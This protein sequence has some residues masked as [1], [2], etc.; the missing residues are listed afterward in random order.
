VDAPYD[1]SAITAGIAHIGVGGFHRAHQAMYV[2]RLLRD[3]RAPDWG[4]LGVGVL[5]SDRAMRDALAA[6]D[7]LYTLVEKHAD[8]TYEP[9]VIGSLVDYVLAPEDPDAA[10]ERL[11]DP[12]I[13][14]VSLTITESGYE[15]D[16]PPAA[17]ALVAEA[18]RRRRARGVDP[19][20]VMSCDNLEANGERARAAFARFTDVEGLAFPSSMVDRIT[21]ATTDDDRRELRERFGIE[22]RWPVVCEPFAQWALE[23]A[24]TAGRPPLQDAGV[25]LVEHVEPYELMKLRLLNGSHQALAYFGALL[26]YELVHDAARDPLLRAFVRQYMDLEATP[27][28]SPVP[29]VDLDD[30]KRTLLER[31]ANPQ[32]RD[33]LARLAVDSRTRLEKWVVP[34]IRAELERAGPIERTC[35]VI[36]AWAEW[37]EAAGEPADVE[38]LLGDPRAVAAV[39]E[40]R[41]ALRERGVRATLEALA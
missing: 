37:R 7:H 32:I 23:D 17:Y 40:A 21:P 33:T 29:G 41:T 20:T 19:F 31:F 25:Q 8:G 30:Y 2:D 22:D 6:Q 28:L 1:R 26:G 35:A 12:A 3:G 36:A 15:P 34:V 24:F 16:S 14:I 5:P 13:R 9:R 39:G 11:A 10:A 4:I 18:L 38:A 27:T